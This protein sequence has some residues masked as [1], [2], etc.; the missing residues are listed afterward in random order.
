MTI[1]VAIISDTPPS[2]LPVIASRRPGTTRQN[3]Y[4]PLEIVPLHIDPE[5]ERQWREYWEYVDQ[6]EKRNKG[7]TA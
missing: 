4:P 1:F 3:E 7:V 2:L 5:W 6:V